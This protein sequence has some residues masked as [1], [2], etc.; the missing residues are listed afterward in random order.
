MGQKFDTVRDDGAFNKNTKMFVKKADLIIDAILGIGFKGKTVREPVRS[1]IIFINSLKKKVLS[2]DIPSGLN[3]DTG[4]VSD[5]AVKSD[6]T[7]TFC[8]PKKGFYAKTARSYTGKVVVRDIGIPREAVR[9]FI[10]C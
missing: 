7:V 4:A 10:K 9:K 6:V 3:A 1:A 2:V 5:C 8:A